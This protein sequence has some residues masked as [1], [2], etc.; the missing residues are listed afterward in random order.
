VVVSGKGFSQL[1]FLGKYWRLENSRRIEGRKLE[2]RETGDGGP[3]DLEA[4]R[5]GGGGEERGECWFSEIANSVS[6]ENRGS[7]ARYGELGDWRVEGGQSSPQ[8]G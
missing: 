4:K 1:A 7:G 8:M 5:T 2:S 6:R 3:W